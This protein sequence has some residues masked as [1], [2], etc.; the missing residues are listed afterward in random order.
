MEG[1]IRIRA[2]Q[3]KSLLAIVRSKSSNEVRRALIVRHE[4]VG[5]RVASAAT[6]RRADRSRLRDESPANQAFLAVVAAR[7]GR[8][9]SESQD[10]FVLDDSR[11]TDR[12]RHARQQ[13]ETALGR[14]AN[15]NHEGPPCA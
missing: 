3:R 7:R 5:L 1:S 4:S 6:G 15:L 11:R 2:K 12:S 14:V 13:R 10:R 9:A 8:G